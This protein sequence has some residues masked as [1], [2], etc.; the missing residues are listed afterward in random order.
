MLHNLLL[1]F[2]AGMERGANSSILWQLRHLLFGSGFL[3]MQIIAISLSEM[4]GRLLAFTELLL[5]ILSVSDKNM[6]R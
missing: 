1:A 2:P 5:E 6:I 3:L 4:P